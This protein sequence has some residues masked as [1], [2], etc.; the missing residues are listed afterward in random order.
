MVERNGHFPEYHPDREPAREINRVQRLHLELLKLTRFND[1]DGEQVAADLEA[2]PRLWRAA[3]LG[4]FGHGGELLALRDMERGFYNADT[5]MIL[6][7][8]EHAPF[9]EKLAWRWSAKEVGWLR[10]E[11]AAEALGLSPV[12]KLK[13]LR[14]WWD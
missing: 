3:M 10:D 4:N 12:G 8:K 7:D 6:T 2:Y 11:E 5:L 9:M 13:I 14:C 1:M